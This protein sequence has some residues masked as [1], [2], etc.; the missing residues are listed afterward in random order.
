L[1][2]RVAPGQRRVIADRSCSEV[3]RERLAYDPIRP[4]MSSMRPMGR[5]RVV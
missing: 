2:V 4:I 3:L 1:R 5:T